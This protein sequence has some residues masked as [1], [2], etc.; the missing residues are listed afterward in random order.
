MAAVGA[1]Y[2]RTHLS[3]AEYHSPGGEAGYDW[4]IPTLG[5]HFDLLPCIHYTPPSLSRTG[6]SSG[7]PVRPRDCAD[8]VDV[9]LTRYGMHFQYLELWNEPNNLLDWDWREDP[10]WQVFC[11]MIG[12]AVVLDAAS[13]GG[14]RCSAVPVHSMPIG[15]I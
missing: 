14:R 12:A 6:Q 7:P 4:L 8:F 5:K 11:E 13:R 9:V 2:L 10:D 3:W 15:C 1:A